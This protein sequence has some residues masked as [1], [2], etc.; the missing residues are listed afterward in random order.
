MNVF[1]LQA[2]RIGTAAFA[3][4]VGIVAAVAQRASQKLREYIVIEHIFLKRCETIDRLHV[5]GTGIAG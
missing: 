4:D 3:E 2:K 1:V 5:G